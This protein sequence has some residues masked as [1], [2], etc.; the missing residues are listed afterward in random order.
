MKNMLF[1]ASVVG[2]VMVLLSIAAPDT[3]AD[4]KY[5]YTDY[6]EMVTLLEDLESQS[7]LQTPDV[8][9]LQIIGYSYQG[10]PIYAVKFSDNPELEEDDEP[11]VVF[12]SGIH[13][14]EWLPVESNLTF[15]QYLFDVYYD[16]LHV[17][18]AEVADLVDNFEIWILPMLNPDGRI[19]DDISGGDPESFWTDTSYHPGD[20]DGWRMNL[21]EVKCPS[22]PA[23]TNQGIC[24]RSHSNI[25]PG[26][27]SSPGPDRG[28]GAHRNHPRGSTEPDPAGRWLG[29]RLQPRLRPGPARDI[30]RLRGQDGT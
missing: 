8:Y 24:A 7:S 3:R 15:I 1:L 10:N 29:L 2:I 21:Q 30:L 19:R 28:T 27:S 13:A 26:P 17:D 18:H 14:N 4:Y 23:G 6:N 9:A 20:S 25:L 12:D 5:N 22:M 16:D 11:D